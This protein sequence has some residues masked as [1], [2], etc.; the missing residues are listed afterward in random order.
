MET[1]IQPSYVENNFATHAYPN[2]IENETLNYVP[3][4]TY[5]SNY[6][7]ELLGQRRKLDEETYQIVEMNRVFNF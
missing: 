3:R 7:Q 6:Y 2:R 4:N 5:K 1:P